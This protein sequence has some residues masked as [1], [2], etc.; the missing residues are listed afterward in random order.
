V[1]GVC[2]EEFTVIDLAVVVMQRFEAVT[3]METEL[4][5]VKLTEMEVPLVGPEMVAPVPFTVQLYE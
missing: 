4:K 1:P 3:E 2:G 5:V